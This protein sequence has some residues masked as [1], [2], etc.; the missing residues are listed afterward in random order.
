MLNIFRKLFRKHYKLNHEY[1]VYTKDIIVD[2][3]WRQTK[4]GYQKWMRKLSYWRSTGKFASQV[5]I[6]HQFHLLDGYS[7]VRIAE[8]YN[9]PKIPVYFA[10]NKESEK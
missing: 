9:I 10:E 5:I 1:W 4:I 2:P 3:S 8:I 7:T 6:D